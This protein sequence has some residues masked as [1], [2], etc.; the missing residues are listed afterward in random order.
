MRSIIVIV[1]IIA[2]ANAAPYASIDDNSIDDDA[3]Y[4]DLS[5]YGK[6]IFGV[7][8]NKTGQLIASYDPHSSGFNPEELGEYLEGDMLMPPDFGRNGLIA[9]STHWPNGVVPFE[10]SGY[11][12]NSSHQ[13]CALQLSRREQCVDWTT[14]IWKYFFPFPTQ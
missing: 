9:S 13:L 7:P 10:I 3:T 14:F 6:S 5:Q 12:G 2:A 8:S 4:I 11:F 1:L